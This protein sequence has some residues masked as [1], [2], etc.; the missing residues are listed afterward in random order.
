MIVLRLKSNSLSHR[1]SQIFRDRELLVLHASISFQPPTKLAKK[2]NANT[3]AFLYTGP[4]HFPTPYRHPRLNPSIRQTDAIFLYPHKYLLPVGDAISLH[5]SS[6][7]WTFVE[8]R[9]RSTQLKHTIWHSC[10]PVPIPST[11]PSLQL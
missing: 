9:H 7:H 2:L 8:I 1:G 3:N 11:P 4:F 5:V 6:P 10:P